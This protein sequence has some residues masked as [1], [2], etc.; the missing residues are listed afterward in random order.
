[1][2]IY[3][4]EKT[5]SSAS[6]VVTTIYESMKL[7]PTLSPHTKINSKWLQDLI[8]RHNTIKLLEESIGKTFSNINCI[9]VFLRLLS[10][11]DR[12]KNENKLMDLI[13]L[14]SFCTAKETMNKM[15]RQPTAWE[16]IFA[17]DATKKGLILKIYKQLIQL[18]NNK[19]K[20]KNPSK[21]ERT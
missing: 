6:S 11:G 15:K 21:N 8:I 7:E 14:I 12:N 16:T 9:N 13:K 2:R 4:G 20:T 3:N 10:Q 5:V 1:M 17:N 19:K 18:D